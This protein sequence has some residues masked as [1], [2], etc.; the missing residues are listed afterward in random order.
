[1]VPAKCNTPTNIIAFGVPGYVPAMILKT[2]VSSQLGLITFQKARVC[3][4][5]S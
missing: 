1:M 3:S 4:F 2:N 5:P